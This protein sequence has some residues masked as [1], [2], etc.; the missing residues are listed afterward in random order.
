MKGNNVKHFIT[1]FNDFLRF[2]FIP[3]VRCPYGWKRIVTYEPKPVI[4]QD[5]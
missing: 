3:M 1:I 5:D 4:H 2:L